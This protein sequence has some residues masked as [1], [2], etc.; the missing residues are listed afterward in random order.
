M[1]ANGACAFTT[2][3]EMD[4]RKKEKLEAAGWRVGSTSE[5]LGLTEEESA[6]VDLRVALSQKL[7]DRRIKSGLSQKELASKLRSSQSRI[8]KME[9]SDPSVSLDLLFKGLLATGASKSEIGKTIASG[10]PQ[11]ARR[12]QARRTSVR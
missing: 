1:R 9:A 5:F 7:R 10:K 12:T 6:L 11:K 4:K 3:C 2:A 8:A